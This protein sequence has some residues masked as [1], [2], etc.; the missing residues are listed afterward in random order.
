ME[1]YGPAEW[2]R[3]ALTCLEQPGFL[4]FS[5]ILGTRIANGKTL[6]AFRM[7]EDIGAAGSIANKIVEGW[8]VR[9]EQRRAPQLLTLDQEAAVR[10]SFFVPGLERYPW[11]ALLVRAVGAAEAARAEKPSVP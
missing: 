9:E 5:R 2:Y 3:N 10:L 6:D 8:P 4:A 1:D 7:L 11:P